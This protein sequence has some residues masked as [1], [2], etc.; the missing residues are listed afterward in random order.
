[1]LIIFINY[2]ITLMMLGFDNCRKLWY[3]DITEHL[4]QFFVA[5]PTLQ[6]QQKIMLSMLSGSTGK[7]HLT[8]RKV[9]FRNHLQQSTQILSRWVFSVQS[10][11]LIFGEGTE[12]HLHLS[13]TACS[14]QHE[15]KSHQFVFE[16]KALWVVLF[17]VLEAP[18]LPAKTSLCVGSPQNRCNAFFNSNS[19]IQQQQ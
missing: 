6:L 3:H 1:M 12:G 4:L 18:E 7:T 17:P 9:G 15:S 16:S 19:T 10:K 13:S 11:M 8:W 2:D 5:Q 14:L